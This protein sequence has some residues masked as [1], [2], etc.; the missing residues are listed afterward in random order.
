VVSFTP[1]PLYTQ[2]NP[3]THYTEGW[4]GRRAGLYDFGE[5]KISFSSLE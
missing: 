2:E 5:V 1:R 3:D 4:V